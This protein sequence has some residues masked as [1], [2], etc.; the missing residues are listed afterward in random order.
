MALVS[1]VVVTIV[2]EAVLAIITVFAVAKIALEADVV[3]ANNSLMSLERAQA[4]PHS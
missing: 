2:A 3:P 1:A 4:V